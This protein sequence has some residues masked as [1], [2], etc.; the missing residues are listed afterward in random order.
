[1][2]TRNWYLKTLSMSVLLASLSICSAFA[3]ESSTKVWRFGLEEIEGSVQD[4]YA[5]AFKRKVEDKSKG[6][7]LVD[8]YSYGMLGE[9][10]DLTNLTANGTLQLTH[11]SVGI[12]GA[13]IPEMQVFTIP[14][15]YSNN[16]A[17]TKDVLATNPTIYEIVGNAL[18]DKD[19]RL[20]TLY[21]EGD[22]VWSTNKPIRKPTDFNE[23]SMRVMNSS[24][25]I[26]TFELLGATPVPMPYSQ[27]YG[28]LQARIVSGQTNPV[29][30]I[31]EMKFYEVTEYLIWAGQQKFTTS[32]LA[33][34]AWYLSLSPAHKRMLNET[35]EEL[36]PYIFEQQTA[37]NSAQLAAIKKSKP[38][39]G[40]IKLT[41]REQAA[42]K[43]AS[44]PVRLQYIE[45]TGPTG[46]RLL[47][48]LEVALAPSK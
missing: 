38:S 16:D 5:Q 23:F 26:K 4:I 41:K 36:T 33:N 43:A 10:E 13:Y 20:M 6:E 31:E 8:I 40:I 45:N 35:I 44:A 30:S 48:A 17:H 19:L 34:Q 46:Q 18:I 39:M 9:S 11:A 37:L 22:M 1:M 28:A 27:V 15:L 42:F 7:V 2:T 32:V 14:Y 21:L 12:L 29:F 24:L 25:V 47:D 3:A